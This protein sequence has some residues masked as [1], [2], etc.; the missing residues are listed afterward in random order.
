MSLDVIYAVSFF[1][2]RLKGAVQQLERLPN[3]FISL[4]LYSARLF[5]SGSGTLLFFLIEEA[6]WVK[7]YLSLKGRHSRLIPIEGKSFDFF[8]CLQEKSTHPP[9]DL[10]M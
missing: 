7:S 1:V 2:W 5:S 4:L 6:A 3:N 10:Q 9:V 8:N